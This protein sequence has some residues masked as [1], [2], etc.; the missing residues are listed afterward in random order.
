MEEEEDDNIISNGKSHRL[1]RYHS[2]IL[3]NIKKDRGKDLNTNTATGC[4]NFGG[5]LTESK[6]QI[7]SHEKE[8]L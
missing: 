2:K 8:A 6:R 4:R 7:L 5:L 1:I 3:R